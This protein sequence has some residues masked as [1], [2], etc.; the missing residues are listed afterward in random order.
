MQLPA[1]VSIQD[2]AAHLHQ[3]LEDLGFL[4]SLLNSLLEQGVLSPYYVEAVA[5]ILGFH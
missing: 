5:Y 4:Q 3:D 1:R 2:V